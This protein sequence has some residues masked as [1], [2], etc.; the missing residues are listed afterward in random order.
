M[1]NRNTAPQ[2]K[3]LHRKL[4]S[5]C[6][7]SR[8]VAILLVAVIVMAIVCF[9]PVYQRYRTQGEIVACAT[10]LDSAR[11]Q[12]AA[13]YMLDGFVNGDAEDAKALVTYAMNGWDDLCPDGGNVY[14]VPRT[15]DDLAWDVVC[16]LHCADKKLCTRLNSDN[17]LQQLRDGLHREQLLDNPYPESLAFTL[18]HRQYTAYLVDEATNFKRG[19]DLTKDYEGIVAFYSIVGHSD[20]GADSGLEDG[21]LWY[22]SFADEN[23]C[24]TWTN[25]QLWTGDSYKVVG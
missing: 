11:R 1:E 9:I 12:L 6:G 23:H 14:I 25:S 7:I 8:L 5:I 24:A 2:G 10:A 13:G 18:H 21:E 17:V 3:R 4:Y 22:F 15:E 20:F 19:T 16:G